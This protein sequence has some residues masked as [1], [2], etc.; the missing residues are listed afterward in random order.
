MQMLRALKAL[1]CSI[2]IS[3][4]IIV[5]LAAQWSLIDFTAGGGFSEHEGK[6]QRQC[7]MES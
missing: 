6:E 3:M 7:G 5:G 4:L 1:C 2:L